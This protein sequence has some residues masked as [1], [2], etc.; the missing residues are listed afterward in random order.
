MKKML[1]FLVVF[2]SWM[3][4]GADIDLSGNWKGETA[5]PDAT[6]PDKITL[7]LKKED[8][9][10]AGKIS[11]SLGMANEV[12]CEDIELKENELTMNLLITNFDGAYVRIYMKATVEGNT[13]T[14]YWESEDGNSSTIKL[15]KE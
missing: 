11:D 15:I 2:M 12:E 14:G 4:F 8:G 10:Y 13:M 9:G 7:V 5:V 1:V 6:E 3:A